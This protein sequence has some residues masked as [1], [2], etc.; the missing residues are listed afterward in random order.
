MFQFEIK[1]DDL[2]DL[3]R[4]SVD[5]VVI[6]GDVVGNAHLK[7]V[8]IAGPN[9]YGNL[10]TLFYF[11]GSQS[12]VHDNLPLSYAWDFGDGSYA[13]G[14]APTHQYSERGN[15]TVSLIVDDGI[16]Q[17]VAATIVAN[18][19]NSYP[20][21]IAEMPSSALVGVPLILDA[22]ASTDA[23][24][25]ELFFKW[26]YNRSGENRTIFGTNAIESFSFPE[27]GDFWLSLSVT[28]YSGAVSASGYKSILVSVTSQ[29]PTADAGADQQ[30]GRR[31]SVTLDGSNSVDPEGSAL[32]YQ[33][34]QISGRTVSLSGAN[35]AV[36]SFV[37][38]RVA[39]KRIKTLVF[40]LTVTDA[41]G[42]TSVDSITVTVSK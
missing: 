33:W 38:P 17:S 13:T 37:G 14:A 20:Q 27:A 2:R 23:D 5:D 6:N 41:D 12:V 7:P 11:D 39:R 30:V 8:A 28:D 19:L 26:W 9:L 22:S 31:A 18:V 34:L 3:G 24:G 21:A 36:A 25:D 35:T 1:Q 16:Y 40:E 42:M 32:S 15:F 4:W 29:T 10:D